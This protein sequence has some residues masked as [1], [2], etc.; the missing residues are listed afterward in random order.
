MSGLTTFNRENTMT[1]YT[2]TIRQWAT[3][4]R[5]TGTLPEADGTGEVGLDG[6]E[7][8]SKI[9]VRFTLK[10]KQDYIE[11][12]RYQVFGCGFSMAACAVA[13]DLSVGYHMDKVSGINATKI[14]Q[15]L[16]GLPAD[17]SYCAELA[18]EALSAAVKSARNERTAIHTSIKTEDEHGSR[19]KANDP[20][21]ALLLKTQRP[22]D[23]NPEDRHLF[24]CLLNVA[25]QEAGSPSSALG[26]SEGDLSSLLEKFFPGISRRDLSQRNNHVEIPPTEINEDV[27]GILLNHV[28][29]SSHPN[30]RTTSVWLCHILATRASQPGHLWVAMGLFERP[31]LTASIRRHLP[32]LAEANDQNMRWK[33]YLYKQVCDNNGGFM[34]KAPNCGVCSDYALCFV[35]DN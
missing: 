34:C 16:K 22:P 26:L 11:D 19:T 7:A 31:E 9:A 35:E 14:D 13:A 12:I 21:Y 2:N 1:G 23:V 33:R 32:S 30:E 8:G 24:A 27:L 10:V 18:A 25:C 5:R 20:V 15:A 3:D 29:T 6:P 17:R 4:T 28:P